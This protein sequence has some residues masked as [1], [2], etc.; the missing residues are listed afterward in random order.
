M[1]RER[2]REEGWKTMGLVNVSTG[3]MFRPDPLVCARVELEAG[4]PCKIEE[5]NFSPW[6]KNYKSSLHKPLYNSSLC[7]FRNFDSKIWS[8]SLKCTSKEL[9]LRID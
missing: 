3:N 8:L 5:V 2:E 1:G 9:S 6:Y 4:S 7:S